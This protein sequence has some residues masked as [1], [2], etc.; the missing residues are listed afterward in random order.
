MQHRLAVLNIMIVFPLFYFISIA[1]HRIDWNTPKKKIG[2]PS[3]FFLN[4]VIRILVY[5]H[6][7]SQATVNCVIAIFGTMG[8]NWWKK[9]EHYRE[10]EHRGPNEYVGMAKLQNC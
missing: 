9:N 2:L 8:A 3:C 7:C 1:L 4:A 6:A 5:V 10:R